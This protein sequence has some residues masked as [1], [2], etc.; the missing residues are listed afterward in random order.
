LLFQAVAKP[1]KTK[2][3]NASK[4]PSYREGRG[5]VGGDNRTLYAFTYQD[6]GNVL[7]RP[8]GGP[9]ED[10]LGMNQ[11]PTKDVRV[12]T[13]EEAEEHWQ[14]P[15]HPGWKVAER[16]ASHA[17]NRG[18]SSRRKS[19]AELDSDIAAILGSVPGKSSAHATKKGSKK[20][21]LSVAYRLQLTP[22]ELQAVEFASGRYAWPDMLAAH[23]TEGGL[24]AFTEPE[25][26]QWTDDVDSE[27]SPFSLASPAF[28][29][30]LQRFYDSRV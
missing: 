24:V 2:P 14:N 18:S 10:L 1:K 7:V 16:G 27:D 15:I 11:G 22:S 8:G 19:P 6:T 13:R 4:P 12:A 25:M 21:T 17:L 29:E 9:N 30:K 28:A 26:W 23:V 3:K 20:K 5:W